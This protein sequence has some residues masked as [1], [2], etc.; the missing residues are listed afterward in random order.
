[1]INYYKLCN[2]DYYKT[3]GG[4]DGVIEGEIFNIEKLRK[5][6]NKFTLE[7]QEHVTKFIND[8]K[9]LF[10]IEYNLY[11]DNSTNKLFDEKYYFSYIRLT[12]DTK[13]DL[14]LI[15]I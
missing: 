9:K 7:H 3:I 2:I 14:N 11:K 15:V 10:N 6:E 12:L 4:I 1:M 13:E 5:Y 8:N